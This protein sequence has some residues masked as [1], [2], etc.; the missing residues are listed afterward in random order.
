[1]PAGRGG[2]QLLDSGSGILPALRPPNGNTNS[3][4][5]EEKTTDQL[6]T[7]NLHNLYWQVVV[8]CCHL[9]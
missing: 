5:L 4:K 6:M 3:A 7:G 8:L 9:C 1:M 2:K